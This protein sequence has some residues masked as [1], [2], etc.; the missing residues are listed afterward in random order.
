MVFLI[1]PT[2]L[3]SDI[4][5]LTNWINNNSKNNQIIYLI[6][7]P[8]YFTDFNYHKLKL[9]YHRASMKKYFDFLKN[10]KLNVKY[11]DYFKVTKLFYS[12]IK[13]ESNTISIIDPG[14][15]KLKKKLE[16]IF[17]KKLIIL[18]NINW[19]ININE[20]EYIKKLIY[21]NSN[22][23]HDKF[24]KYQRKKLDI[25]IDS[26]NKPDGGKWSY[27]THNRLA[28]PKNH[29]VPIT[30]SK[31]LNNKY[32]KEAINYVNKNWSNNYGSLEHFIYPIDTNSSLK[33]LDKFLKERLCNFGPY[34]DAVN[35]SEPFIY[36]SVLSPMMNIGILTDT[37]V[38]TKS[39]EY[40]LAHKKYISIE[41]FEGFIRQVIGWRNYVYTVY[42]LEGPKLFES[43]NLKH[44]TKLNDKFWTGQ[45]EIK[46]IDSIIN[47]LVTYAYAHHIERLMYL[48][49]FM[50][51]CM[52]DPKEVYRIFME[53]TIDAYE[54]VM[55][56][57]IF[58]MS[59]YA[60]GGTMMT[61]PYF[62][63][64]NYINKMSSY[65]RDGEWDIIWDALY[66][67]FI[68]KHDKL[69]KNNYATA[70]QV[71]HWYNKTDKEKKSIKKI[72]KQYLTK[73]F[74]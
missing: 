69:L 74:N 27:D 31:K 25:L 65:K 39:Y 48:G 8:I 59:Q 6:E 73:L 45:T 64:S 61:R 50:L 16:T 9:A 23:S 2:Q 36:H 56:P 11:I 17:E 29:K 51:I 46:P 22:Y 26:T 10:K 19:L 37:Q 58:G 20:L 53:W 18:D 66:Y 55:I 68:N 43:N 34:E 21:T 70:I 3:F 54:W 14:D 4:K 38:V 41:S 15:F 52:V 67:N 44:K 35:E 30:I 47:K 49:N 63:S 12:S 13:S 62:S 57:N 32:V 60:D 5:H 28:L 40:Y 24:Y 1:F 42:M 71:K 33:W 72:A 7:E